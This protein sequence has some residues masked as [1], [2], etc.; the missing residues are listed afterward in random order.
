MTN[1]SLP[2]APLRTPL[3]P[4]CRRHDEAWGLSQD[5]YQYDLAEFQIN[6]A[7]ALGAGGGLDGGDSAAPM[8]IATV[9]LPTR[10]VFSGLTT[11]RPLG[12]LT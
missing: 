9:G 2:T 5:E 7:S 4:L 1:S 3:G 6:A 11:E 8:L 12:E 10:S